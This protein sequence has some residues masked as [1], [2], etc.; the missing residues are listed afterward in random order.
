MPWRTDRQDLPDNFR[1]AN[2]RLEGLEKRLKTDATLYSRYNDVIQDYLQQG[3]CE[4]VSENPAAAEQP[5]TVKYYMPHHAVLRED[6]VTIKLR[7][8]GGMP[9][10]Q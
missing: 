6:K 7:V 4:D 1:V 5:E 8:R 9:F 10:T 2:G 3:I